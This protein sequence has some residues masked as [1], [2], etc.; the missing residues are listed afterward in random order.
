ML[1]EKSEMQGERRNGVLKMSGVAVDARAAPR[2]N[3]D[4]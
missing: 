1:N 2:G 3:A 4:P